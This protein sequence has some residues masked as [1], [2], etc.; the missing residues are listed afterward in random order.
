M[1]ALTLE[2]LD[3]P[4]KYGERLRK[5]ISAAILGAPP[6]EQTRIRRE[7]ERRRDTFLRSFFE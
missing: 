4:Y 5:L 2:V 3:A 1:F 6:E 7:H